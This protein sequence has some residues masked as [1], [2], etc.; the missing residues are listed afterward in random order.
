MTLEQFL[1]KVRQ[2]ESVSFQ[3]TMAIITENYRYQPVGFSNGMG[4]DRIV[5]AAGTNEGSCKIF[6]FAKLNQLNEQQTLKLFGDYYRKDVLANPGGTDH[7]NI[8]HFM[9]Y[10]WE[11]IQYDRLAL[12]NLHI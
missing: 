4:E 1:T 9:K 3:E 11:G 10:G 7:Q 5:N 2:N 6:A 12:R 8:R